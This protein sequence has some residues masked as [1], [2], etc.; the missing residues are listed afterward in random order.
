VSRENARP[1][2]DSEDL[3]EKVFDIVEALQEAGCDEEDICENVGRILS[4]E[5]PAARKRAAQSDQQKYT[6]DC[7]DEGEGLAYDPDE[8]SDL[9]ELLCR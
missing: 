8:V 5:R 3:S 7:C 2:L 1:A 6:Y 9:E 4:Y